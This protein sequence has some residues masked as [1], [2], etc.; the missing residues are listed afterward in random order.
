MTTNVDGLRLVDGGDM[1][2]TA[3]AGD[4]VWSCGVVDL[5]LLMNGLDDCS[6]Y[7]SVMVVAATRCSGCRCAACGVLGSLGVLV[8]M[9]VGCSVLRMRDGSA[10]C[11]AV[12]WDGFR[13]VQPVC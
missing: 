6:K 10:S 12:V 8:A 3:L 11:C 1:T 2:D 4:V 5:C 7:V 9:H 13:D